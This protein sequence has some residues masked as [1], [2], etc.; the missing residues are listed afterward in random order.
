MRTPDALALATLTEMVGDLFLN[1]PGRATSV[2]SWMFDHAGAGSHGRDVY[3]YVELP[4]PNLPTQI[5]HSS[6]VRHSQSTRLGRFNTRQE[7]VHIATLTAV[8]WWVT[9]RTCTHSDTVCSELV[10]WDYSKSLSRY[11]EGSTWGEHV[12]ITT[13]SVLSLWIETTVSHWVDTTRVQHEGNMC[14]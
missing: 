6:G 8:S 14:I 13:L 11:Y 9:W 4:D 10:N 2:S 5:R 3:L 12:H 1:R 7:H